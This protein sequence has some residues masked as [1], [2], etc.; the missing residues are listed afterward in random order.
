MFYL[1][2]Y[3]DGQECLSRFPR[4]NN[5][6]Q[7]IC[8]ITMQESK[9]LVLKHR[10]K[11]VE[12]ALYFLCSF[13]SSRT[14]NLGSAWNVQILAIHVACRPERSAVFSISFGPAVCFV[15]QLNYVLPPMF[16][17][18]V[19]NQLGVY[20]VSASTVHYN[21]NVCLVIKLTINENGCSV[22]TGNSNTNAPQM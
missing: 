3:F 13:F 14:L 4:R 9:F 18:N 10:L 17:R 15:K 7:L 21:L 2:R 19:C 6:F 1:I 11:N 5:S 12:C 8:D 16:L 22:T 20:T